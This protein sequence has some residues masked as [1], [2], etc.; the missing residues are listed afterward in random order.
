MDNLF[1]RIKSLLDKLSSKPRIDGLQLSDA[2]LE[3]V[4]FEYEKPKTVA[5]R[6]PPGILKNGKLEDSAQFLG[7]VKNST[8]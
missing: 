1:K 8:I 4:F 2:G 6:L 5:L 7:Y 3:Y